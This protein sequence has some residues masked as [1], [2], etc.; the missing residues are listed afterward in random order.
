[1]RT[2]EAKWTK[3]ATEVLVGRT[4]KSVKYLHS[5]DMDSMWAKKPIVIYLDNGVALIPLSD[6]EGNDG[7]SLETTD[8]RLPIIPVL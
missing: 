5:S 3:L 4:I 7:G 6:D 1:M 2:N 8:K